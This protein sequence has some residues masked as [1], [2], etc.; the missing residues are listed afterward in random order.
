MRSRSALW[1]RTEQAI[2][3]K[4]FRD[5]LSLLSV[6][7]VISFFFLGGGEESSQEAS[8]CSQTCPKFAY[9]T[10][11]DFLEFQILGTCN[12]FPPNH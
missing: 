12:Q 5:A 2:D 4:A 7:T 1:A 10:D 8:R 11:G 6:V 3:V 9:H